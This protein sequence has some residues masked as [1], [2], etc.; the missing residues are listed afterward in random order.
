MILFIFLQLF[1]LQAFGG[2][3]LNTD[4]ADV[5]GMHQGQI[6][7]WIF[8]DRRS[9]QHWLVPTV[10]I[11]DALEISASGVHGFTSTDIQGNYSASGP[12]LQTKINLRK[13]KFDL[14]PGIGFAA[15]AVPP[16]GF[17]VF[18][19][20]IWEYFF[21]MAA[22][23]YPLGN[24]RLLLH[25]N[26]GRQTRKQFTDTPSA[27]LW[28]AAIELLILEHTYA[29]VEASNGEVYGLAPGSVSQAGIRYEFKPGIQ[30]DGTFGNGLSGEPIQPLWVSLGI[31]VTSDHLL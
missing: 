11:N 15:G 29:F 30:I 1:V 7:T 14:L 21:Y 3:P 6:E 2:R 5:I 20:P 23:I 25:V 26:L 12:I 24:D 10:G 4:D 8:A 16:T 22:S 13:T 19:S 28:G 9:F 27:L 17:G 31:K 18:K